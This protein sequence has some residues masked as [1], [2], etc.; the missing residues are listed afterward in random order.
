MATLQQN[1]KVRDTWY[2]PAYG[3]AD[4]TSDTAELIKNPAAFVPPGAKVHDL[5]KLASTAPAAEAGTPDDE[6]EAELKAM[7]KAE[8]LEEAER[9][10]ADVPKTAKND[11]IIRAIRAAE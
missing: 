3:N 9:V 8:L 1:V 7:K 4:I 6:R 10:G 11:D 2:G 5:S